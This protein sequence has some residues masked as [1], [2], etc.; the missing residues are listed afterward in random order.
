MNWRPLTY[1]QHPAEVIRHFTPNWFTMTMGT[2]I[3]L[4]MI[5]AF[6]YP[7]P[8]QDMTARVLWWIDSAF[9]GLFTLL[10]SARLVLETDSVRNLLEHPV[11]SMFLGAIPMGLV[12]IING[13][14]LFGMPV[15]LAQDLWWLDAA[16]AAGCGWL[17]P[18]LMFTRQQHSLEGMTAV[19][20]LPIVASEVTASSGG[21]LA[22][23]LPLAAARTVIALSY[24]L[25][26]FS[27]PLAL[28]IVA[29]VFLRL[30]LHKLPDRAMAASS[31]LVLGPLGTGALALLVL[32]EAAGPVF[33]G[34]PLAAAASFARP[35]GV[36]AGAMLWAYGAWWWAMAWLFTL[37]YIRRGLPFNMG[38]WGFTFPLGVYTAATLV[39]AQQSAMVALKVYGAL[40][41]VQLVGFWGVVAARTL[42]GM[43]HGY[44]FNAPC[45]ATEQPEPH[46]A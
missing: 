3:L 9:Y 24:A 26:A 20:L 4:L 37:R 12:P 8:G 41:V 36:I 29:V 30:V 21:Y 13:G 23:H 15:W 39:L 18:Y 2:G 42:H 38:W 46:N 31:W 6:P 25:W 28:G 34:T 16:L 44:L 45:L 5:H 1:K 19:W 40:L 10:F 32:G 27:V 33:A 7:F 14:L 35:F 17:V 43:W 11:Q 22:P